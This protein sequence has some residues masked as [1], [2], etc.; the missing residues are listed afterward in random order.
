VPLK[1]SVRKGV[2]ATKRLP[3][4][5]DWVSVTYA[6]TSD[7]TDVL[8]AAPT[9]PISLLGV[10]VEVGELCVNPKGFAFVGNTFVPPLLVVQELHGVVVEVLKIWDMNL[11][12]R[13]MSWRAIKVTKLAI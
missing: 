9:V 2:Y 12:K 3:S 8:E 10:E 7:G 5:G 1:V 11:K 4:V 6:N 13:E